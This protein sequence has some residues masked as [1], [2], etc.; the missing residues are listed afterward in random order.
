MKLTKQ[1]VVILRALD[2][3]ACGASSREIADSAGIRT[4]SP[5]ETAARHLIK[6]AKLGLSEKVGTR[7]FPMWRVTAAGHREARQ[8]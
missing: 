7:M 5:T 6:L 1:D 8:A 2:Q 3:F 4:T